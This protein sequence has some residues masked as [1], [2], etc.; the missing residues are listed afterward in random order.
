MV[1]RMNGVASSSPSIA[2]AIE[3]RTTASGTART[4]LL[5]AP[6]DQRRHDRSTNAV[7]GKSGVEQFVVGRWMPVARGV[8]EGAED[9]ASAEPVSRD[10][11][12]GKCPTEIAVITSTRRLGEYVEGL[13][14]SALAHFTF[15][16]AL[17]VA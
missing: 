8:T 4:K 17:E 3:R 11:Q 9:V 7:R 2:S 16:D 1:P 10:R 14:D 5:Q 13:G 12:Q 6:S 15:A